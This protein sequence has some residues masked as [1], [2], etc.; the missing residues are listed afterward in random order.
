MDG[1]TWGFIGTLAGAVVGAGAAIISTRMLAAADASQR[2]LERV[3]EAV[4]AIR[5]LEV[6]LVSAAAHIKAT[7]DSNF[8]W[9][10]DDESLPAA[11]T[12]WRENLGVVAIAVP[13]RE[14]WQVIAAGA[15]TIDRAI[16]MRKNRALLRE[17]D[18]HPELAPDEAKGLHDDAALCIRAF[19]LL[20]EIE[21]RQ[22]K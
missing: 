8:W 19:E 14:D 7:V 9:G 10:L 16:A 5:S 11:L 13:R 2:R 3:R 22:D 1:A 15:A 18:P 20:R 12:L 17:A 6:A 21:R 4:G